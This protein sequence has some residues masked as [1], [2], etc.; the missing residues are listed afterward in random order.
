MAKGRAS[1]VFSPM[2]RVLI[3]VSGNYPHKA[4]WAH[5]GDVRGFSPEDRRLGYNA[6]FSLVFR[7]IFPFLLFPR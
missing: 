3:L 2:E 1:H 4:G 7:Q 5:P 6:A